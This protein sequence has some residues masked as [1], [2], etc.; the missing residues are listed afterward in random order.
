MTLAAWFTLLVIAVCLVLLASSRIS[1][2][3]VMLGGLTVLMLADILPPAKALSGFSNEGML[4]VAALYVVASGLRETG[5]IQ[6]VI[7]RLM[8]RPKTVAGAQARIMG[9]VMLMSAFL[10]NTPV[11]ASFIPALQDWARK[12]RFAS[13][14]LMIP[15]SYAAI[16][17]GACTLIGTS[18]NLVVNGLLIA[19]PSTHG[20]ALFDPAW[21]GL[22]AALAGFIYLM[23]FGRRLLPDRHSGFESFKD[24]REYTIEMTING[25]GALNGQTVEEA[26]LRNLPGCFLVEIYRED[27]IIPAVSPDEK[28]R[29]GDRLIFAGIVESIVDLQKIKGLNPATDQIF[30]LDTPRRERLLV[31]AVVSPSHPLNGKTIKEGGFREIYDAVVLAVS[32]NGERVKQKVGDIE[33]QTGDTLLLETQPSFIE[34]YRNNTDY[35]LVSS[36]SDAQHFE[37]E[38]AGWAWS[39][40]GAMVVLAGTGVLSM[41]KASFLAAGMMLLSGCTRIQA[42]RKSMDYRVLLVIAAAL[43]LGQALQHTGAAQTLAAQIMSVAKSN[44]YAALAATYII[45]WLLTELITN[46]AAAVLVFPIAIG[47]AGSLG[48]SYLPFVMVIIMAASASFITPIGYQTNLMVYGPGGYHFTDFTKVG[49]PLNIIIAIITIVIAPIAWPF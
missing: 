49:L 6:F 44:P 9:P 39:I 46:N 45:T 33:L 26:G 10:N 41:F 19:E 24:P 20:L 34:R 32:R 4:T 29:T 31:E 14:K 48:V 37:Y 22:P 8:G 25:E 15:L 23:L 7:N 12:N 47:V 17:G 40:L 18:T 42:T 2:D 16:L 27:R 43:G 5:A 1:A 35:F 13:S 30:K 11:V 36:I 28:L 21:I 3:L 38:K